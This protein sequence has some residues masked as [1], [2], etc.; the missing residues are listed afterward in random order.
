VANAA[1]N[2]VVAF[3]KE[4]FSTSIVRFLHE[5]NLIVH[6]LDDVKELC[7]L[8]SVSTT[9][10]QST[11]CLFGTDAESSGL[12]LSSLTAIVSMVREASEFSCVT[13]L[14]D[15]EAAGGYHVLCYA[16]GHSSEE[17]LKSHRVVS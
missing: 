10:A 16:I 5:R 2:V 14:R 1:S 17:N 11:S 13:L 3:S 4:C 6:I 12:W 8:S 15:F 7:G 9:V